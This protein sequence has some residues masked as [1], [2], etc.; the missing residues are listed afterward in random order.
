VQID[1][2]VL[3]ALILH[4]IGG[5]VDRTDFT[6]D[7]GGALKGDVELVEQ[8]AQLGGLC[9]T[10]GHGAVLGLCAGAGDDGLPLG[11]PRDK[12]GSQEHDITGC[13]PTHVGAA[14]PVTV[15]VD[16]ELRRRGW[17]EE[18]SVVERATEVEEDPL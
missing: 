1:L 12:V 8:L 17:S 16:D 9:H 2:H 3:R 5:D 6:V 4:G 11:G 13:G 15:G 14:S 10:V 18:K 7:E